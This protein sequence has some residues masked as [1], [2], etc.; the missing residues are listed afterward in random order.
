MSTPVP[1]YLSA[2]LLLCGQHAYQYNAYVDRKLSDHT[3]SGRT[4]IAGPRRASGASAVL[5]P[6]AKLTPGARRLSASH[7]STTLRVYQRICKHHFCNS[8]CHGN[9]SQQFGGLFFF[10]RSMWPHGRLLISDMF[11]PQALPIAEAD[12]RTV[13][14]S[15]HP[16]AHAVKQARNAAGVADN[17]SPPQQSAFDNGIWHSIPATAGSVAMETPSCS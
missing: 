3:V 8:I 14:E 17:D 16:A 12:A 2:P 9:G 6:S 15:Q 11:F 10:V 13:A 1:L 5:S 4:R 7:W